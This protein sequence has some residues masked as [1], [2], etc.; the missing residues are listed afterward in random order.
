MLPDEAQRKRRE[1]NRQGEYPAVHEDTRDKHGHN[2]RDNYSQQPGV[3]PVA[4]RAENSGGGRP[5]N[6]QRVILAVHRHEHHPHQNPRK[7]AAYGFVPHELGVGYVCDVS[8]AAERHGDFLPYPGNA[9]LCGNMVSYHRNEAHEHAVHYQARL[10]KRVGVAEKQEQRRVENSLN[11]S[12]IVVDLPHQR[13]PVAP[14]IERGNACNAYFVG[15]NGGKL[16]M[17][18]KQ[19]MHDDAHRKDHHHHAAV[20][21][22]VVETSESVYHFLSISSLV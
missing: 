18:G 2:E 9:Q 14:G 3:R 13:R 21:E 6:A 19:R 8:S 20:A 16:H 15:V 4:D 12:V 22:A 5:Q 1:E 17:H 10:V 7:Q 11:V